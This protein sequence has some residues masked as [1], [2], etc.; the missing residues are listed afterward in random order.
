MY[1]RFLSELYVHIRFMQTP[2]DSVL[3]CRQPTHSWLKLLKIWRS[4]PAKRH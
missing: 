2:A 4:P 3:S 1:S